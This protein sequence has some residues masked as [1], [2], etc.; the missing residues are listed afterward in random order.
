MADYI[1]FATPDTTGFTVGAIQSNEHAAAVDSA[2]DR[3]Q[4]GSG[5]MEADALDTF[6]ASGSLLIGTG[7]DAASNTSEV[8]I[9]A[10]G[11]PTIIQGDL[12]IDGNSFSMNVVNVDID[13]NI[14]IINDV[15]SGVSD[16]SGMILG[17]DAGA[18]NPVGMVWNES[19]SEFAFFS[20]AEANPSDA[21]TLDEG[22]WEYENVRMGVLNAIGGE[23]ATPLSS[24]VRA[25]NAS[26]L[27]AI[28]GGDLNLSAGFGDTAG[29]GGNV[30]LSSGAGGIG[31]TGPSGAGGELSLIAGIGGDAASD[32]TGAAG[33][34]GSLSL[35]AGQG[36]AA[37]ATEAIPGAAGGSIAL[38]AGSGGA[39]G[40]LVGADAAA[41]G[42]ISLQ[43][44][45]GGAAGA[46]SN[47]ASGGPIT[48]Q[49]GGSEIEGGQITTNATFTTGSSGEANSTTVE[50]TLASVQ[51]EGTTVTSSTSSS[52]SSH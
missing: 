29:A 23:S 31:I 41:G 43:A 14:I 10:A 25:E 2:A 30:E 37:A 17:R 52:T 36:G 28:S 18:G 49:A 21:V 45:E 32:L 35:T 4:I 6:T 48:L 7:A 47:P 50:S 13:D 12:Q 22:Q 5:T 11:I 3:Y 9:G 33:L 42:G 24:Q 34:G 15:P 38:V 51:A 8:R 46:G 16:D 20:T 19:G 27:S 40:V 1:L 44:G 26:E 39:G